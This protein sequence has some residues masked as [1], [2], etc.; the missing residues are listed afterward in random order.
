MEA[1]IR[2]SQGGE[3]LETG[4]QPEQSIEPIPFSSDS[5]PT[6]SPDTELDDRSR[7]FQFMSKDQALHLVQGFLSS[8]N[9]MIPIWNSEHLLQ[10]MQQDWPPDK[11]TDLVWWTTTLIALSY[12]YRLRAMM[13][14]SGAEIDNKEASRFLSEAMEVAPRLAYRKPS[15]DAAQVLLA[16]ASVMRGSATPETAR[17]FTA[18]AVQMLQELDAH[19]DD[20]LDRVLEDSPT[21]RGRVWWI[22]YI[23]DK[24]IA[25]MTSKPPIIDDRYISRPPPRWQDVEGFGMVRSTDG[26]SEANF[27]VIGYRLAVLMSEVHY[28]TQSP[29]SDLTPEGL[30]ASQTALNPLFDTWRNSLPFIFKPSLVGLWPEHA[31]IYMILLHFQYFHTLLRLNRE[32]PTRPLHAI[33][34]GAP[35]VLRDNICACPYSIAPFVVNAARD[36]LSLASLMPKG[37]LQHVW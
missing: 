23:H 10:R 24:S 28:R 2:R 18:S 35:A 7:P 33:A 22:A 37:N 20:K 19:E 6:M 9:L 25:E 8:C 4:Q 32:P 5:S 17:M 16:I 34:A 3:D 15:L 13:Y 36:A 1:L 11:D 26:L 14:P 21:E 29:T 27:L 30:Q 31:V 12:S